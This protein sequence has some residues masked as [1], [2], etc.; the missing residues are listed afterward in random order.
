MSKPINHSKPWIVEDREN[1][2]AMVIAK[3]DWVM[4]SNLLGRTLNATLAEFYR[5]ANYPNK[6]ELELSKMVQPY[7][8]CYNWKEGHTDPSDIEIE[9]S[10]SI[11]HK[12]LKAL[13][14]MKFF[15]DTDRKPKTILTVKSAITTSNGDVYVSQGKSAELTTYFPLE[16]CDFITEIVNLD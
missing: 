13:L 12:D 10:Q 1:L 2:V 3:Y 16:D 14:G 11:Q 15:I 5:I 4:I 9:E 6:D 7:K 8:N